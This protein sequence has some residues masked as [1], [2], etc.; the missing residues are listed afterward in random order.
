MQ[1]HVCH[2]DAQFND[3]SVIAWC[4]PHLV[5]YAAY[6]PRLHDLVTDE[7]IVFFRDVPP[8]SPASTALMDFNNYTKTSLVSIPATS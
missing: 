6:C 3:W 2:I 1:R 4:P 7:D 8:L 5:T